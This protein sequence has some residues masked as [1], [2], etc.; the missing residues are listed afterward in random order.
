MTNTNEALFDRLVVAIAELRTAAYELG[1]L[2]HKPDPGAGIDVN[3]MTSARWRAMSRH[4]TAKTQ[5]ADA[6]SELRKVVA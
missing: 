4:E 5:V 6:I 1:E 2:V 3:P